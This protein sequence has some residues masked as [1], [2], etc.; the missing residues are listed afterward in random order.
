VMKV[1]DLR[2]KTTV[3]LNQEL[4]SLLREQFNLRMQQGSGAKPR[5][6]NFK[7]VRK[8]IA[9]VKTILKEKVNE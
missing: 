9:R 8:N 6:S 2:V 4:E 1:S 5:A 3:E 7:E